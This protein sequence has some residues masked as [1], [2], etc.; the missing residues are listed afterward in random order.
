MNSRHR[1]K[2]TQLCALMLLVCVLGC[3]LLTTFAE[4]E[5][6]YWLAYLVAQFRVEL[7]AISFL[8]AAII[9]ATSR[10][11][12]LFTVSILCAIVNFSHLI[13]YYMPH[14]NGQSKTK[15]RLLQ[16]NLNVKN[17]EYEKVTAYIQEVNA[18]TVLIE[19]LTPEW[20]EYFSKHL[21]QYPH[22]TTV[23]QIDTYGIGV[24]NKTPFE[25][26]R[27]EYF[28]MARHP[29]IVATLS[30]LE[31]PVTLLHTHV[32]GPVKEP[33]FAWHE[34]QM[35]LMVPAINKLPRPIVLSGDMNANAW[36]YLL[37]DLVSKTDLVDT[38]KGRGIH[39][40]WPAPFYWRNWPFQLLS[41][42]HY[43]VSKD[44]SVSKRELGKSI[45]SDHYPVILEFGLKQ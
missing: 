24:Y 31:K 2:V 36:T 7:F 21:R 17:H 29:S 42:D 13:S 15:L 38:Q 6:L 39:L 33:F 23:E 14:P 5:R 45:F 3:A 1:T 4:C 43:F 9:F 41:I 28:G 8:T 18:D 11:K 34:E 27:V 32:Q 40:S 25:N 26:A 16:M 37:S 19:E 10:S 22:S 20:R 12:I 35:K 30:G 44:I